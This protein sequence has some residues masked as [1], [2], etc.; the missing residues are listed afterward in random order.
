MIE[1]GCDRS[2]SIDL[3]VKTLYLLQDEMPGISVA[4]SVL[5]RSIAVS[6]RMARSVRVSP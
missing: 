1:D 3:L 5:A 4:G 2:S 6:K